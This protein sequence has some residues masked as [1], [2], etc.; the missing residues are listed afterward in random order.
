MGGEEVVN[1]GIVTTP[2]SKETA[3]NALTVR[4]LADPSED[5]DP[6]T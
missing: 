6:I 2:L 3:L 1:Y 5:E 4:H